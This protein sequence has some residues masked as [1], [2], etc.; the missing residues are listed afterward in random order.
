MCWAVASTGLSIV[1]AVAQQQATESNVRAQQQAA[2]Q[3]ADN[4]I[5]SMNYAFQGYEMERQ[6]AFDQ[7]VNEI[8]QTRMNSMQLNAS[9]EAAVNEDYIGGGRTADLINRSAKG[10]ELRAVSSVKDNYK[11]KSNEIDLNKETTLINTK[12][13]IAGIKPPSMPSRLGMV[14]GVGSAITNYG[15]K[16]DDYKTNQKIKKGGNG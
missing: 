2:K 9:V 6:D 5:K 3:Q 14:L 10:D 13:Q 1:G 12:A 8:Q 15:T 7:A 11:R 16:L 4:A